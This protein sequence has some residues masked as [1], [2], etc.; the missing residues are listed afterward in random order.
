MYKHDEHDDHAVQKS[1]NHG[2]SARRWILPKR[3]PSSFYEVKHS[4][5]TRTEQT[6]RDVQVLVQAGESIRSSS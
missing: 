5:L 4:V 6:L 1:K 2:E 3:A